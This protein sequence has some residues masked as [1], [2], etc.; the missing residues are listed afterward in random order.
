VAEYKASLEIQRRIQCEREQVLI[1]PEGI[2]PWWSEETKIFWQEPIA[3]LKQDQRIALLGSRLPVSPHKEYWFNLQSEIAGLNG[4][5][6]RTTRRHESP[7]DNAA[8][9]IGPDQFEFRQAIPVPIAMW[10]PGKQNLGARLNLFDVTVHRLGGRRALVLIC[11]EQ[12]LPWSIFRALAARPEVLIG[13]SNDAW[14]GGTP[15]PRWRST[16]VRAIGRLLHVPVI[17]ATNR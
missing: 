17:S 12:L 10:R 9:T 7:F 15:V 2:I 16:A 14:A 3:A 5:P 13:I 8:V 11:H 1:F 6:V 4:N